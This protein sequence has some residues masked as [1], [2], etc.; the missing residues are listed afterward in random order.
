M[1]TRTVPASPPPA[2]AGSANAHAPA[3][4]ATTDLAANPP[5]RIDDT[6]LCFGSR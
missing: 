2:A 6:R 5:L 4:I 1:R 3:T